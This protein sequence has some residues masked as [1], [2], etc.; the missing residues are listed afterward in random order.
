MK[1]LMKVV[2]K[3]NHVIGKKQMKQAAAVCQE[4]KNDT[5]RI[6]GFIA[7]ERGLD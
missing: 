3:E 1:G 2:I 7:S 4:T 5:S 6:G